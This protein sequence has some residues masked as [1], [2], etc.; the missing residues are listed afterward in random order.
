M[1]LIRPKGGGIENVGAREQG[2]LAAVGQL[3]VDLRKVR[4]RSGV[5]DSQLLFGNL[6]HAAQIVLADKLRHAGANRRLG[7][8]ARHDA[9][10]SFDKGALEHLPE[11]RR[12][13][14]VDYQYGGIGQVVFKT[15]VGNAPHVATGLLGQ[16]LWRLLPAQAAAPQDTLHDDVGDV[17]GKSNSLC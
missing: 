12:D 13:Q 5:D 1:V 4:G 11:V 6:Q 16:F 9:L 3:F 2:G 15:D 8:A 17:Q 10:Q 14:V 7:G